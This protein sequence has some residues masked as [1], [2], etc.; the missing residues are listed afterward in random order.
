MRKPHFELALPEGDWLE[1]R[2][3]DDELRQRIE[4]R[5]GIEV[6]N[7]SALGEIES[8][9]RL[10]MKGKAL[11]MTA[12]LLAGGA[13]EQAKLIPTGFLLLPRALITVHYTDYPVFENIA[14]TIDRQE[15]RTPA[16]VLA[17]LLEAVVDH[18]SDQLETVSEQAASVSH[19]IFYTDLQH[20]GL[21]IETKQL[22]RSIIKLGRASERVSR[23]RYMFLSI[24][25]L[26]KFVI[27]RS[28]DGLNEKTRARLQAVAHDIVSLD[29]F[30]I[31]LSSRIQFLLDAATSLISIRQNDVVKV[32]TVASVVGIPPV[33]LVGIYGMNFRFMPELSWPW[34]YP[35]AV[36]LCLISGLLPYLWFKWRKWI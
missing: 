19:T 21:K 22:G 12:P 13:D 8:S 10:R 17:R 33:L 14:A 2:D 31:S 7:L 5:F 1:L 34:G 18:A 26:A 36:S 32:L 20:R 27:D 23:V 15:D 35:F 9:S 25:R 29:E 30:E 16:A 28:E 6:P 24:G 3:P 4:E 11:I